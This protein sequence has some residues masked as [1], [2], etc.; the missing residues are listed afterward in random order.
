MEIR[1]QYGA[2][3][4]AAMAHRGQRRAR[5]I[6]ERLRRCWEAY[7]SWR[8]RRMTLN[9]LRTLDDRTLKDI[10]LSASEI[11]SAVYGREEDRRRSYD[12]TWWR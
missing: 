8:A 12:E 6:A 1:A 9:I 5:H 3:P 11:A 7:W 10:G 2:T 4:L